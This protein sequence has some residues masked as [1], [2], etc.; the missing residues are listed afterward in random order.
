MADSD[1]FPT[2]A[3]IRVPKTSELVADQIRGQ[4]VRGELAE[5]GFLP[6]EGQLL[7]TLGVSRPTLREAFRILEAEAL[8]SVVR[9]S[10]TG[11]KVHKPSVELVSRY[12]GYVLQSSGTT[13]ADLYDARLAI[14]P[15]VVRRLATARD[16]NA[17]ARLRQEVERLE[18]LLSE[19]AFADFIAGVSEFHRVLIELAGNNTII[20]INQL[21]HQLIAAHQADYIQRHPR[22]VTEHRKSMAMGPRSY[23]KLIDLIEAGA[24]DEAIAHWRLH[25]QNANATWAARGEAERVVDSLGG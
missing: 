20:F 3:R 17:I 10:R 22:P 8:I 13:I 15:H 5:G 6:P 7:A 19:E 9:G 16:P 24:V 2:N 14:E 21:L 25:L 23:V 18:R 4:I 11:A 12:A 1:S